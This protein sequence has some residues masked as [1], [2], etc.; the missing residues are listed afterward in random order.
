[1]AR[2]WCVHH[3]NPGT[4]PGLRAEILHRAAARWGQNDNAAAS[5]AAAADNPEGDK[6]PLRGLSRG[7]TRWIC[8]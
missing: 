7:V 8:L 5:A 4:I 3:C 2:N 1:M 6:G